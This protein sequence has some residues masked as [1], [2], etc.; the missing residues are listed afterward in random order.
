MGR[1]AMNGHSNHNHAG[2]SAKGYTAIPEFVYRQVQATRAAMELRG[3]DPQRVSD[4][5][6]WDFFVDMQ[7]ATVQGVPKASVE[8]LASMRREEPLMSWFREMWDRMRRTGG[9]PVYMP[10]FSRN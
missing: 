10:G 1:A 4:L 8:Q 9:V 3:T 5:R 6:A 7:L 2:E